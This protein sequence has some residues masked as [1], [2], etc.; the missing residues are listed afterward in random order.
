MDVKVLEETK[1][2]IKAEIVGEDHTLCNALRE[3]LWSDKTVKVA[4]YHM[5]HPLLGNP[6]ILVESEKDAKK[7]LF[8]AVERLRKKNKE[9]L[10]LVK[11]LK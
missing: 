10:E 5:E 1:E 3:E 9:I 11:K 6:V 2:R 7:A 8:D 4:G